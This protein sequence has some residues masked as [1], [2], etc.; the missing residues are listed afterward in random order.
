MAPVDTE[1]AR[2]PGVHLVFEDDGPV[3]GVTPGTRTFQEYQQIAAALFAELE[4]S[5]PAGA[6][7]HA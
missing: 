2:E 3:V 5:A 6:R 1:R 4:R 7:R